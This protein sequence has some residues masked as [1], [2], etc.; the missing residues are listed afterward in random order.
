MCEKEKPTMKIDRLI[1]RIRETGSPIALGLDTRFE[2][3]PNEF[4]KGDKRREEIHT[5]ITEFNE[6]LMEG[7]KDIVPCVKIQTACYERYGEPGIEAMSKTISAARDM[8]YIVI[9]DGKRGDIG[10]TVAEYSKAYLAKKASFPADF[11]TVSPYMGSDSIE[12]FFEDCKETGSGLFVLVKTSNPSSGEFQDLT[13]SD[14][15][16]LYEHVADKVSEWGKG[17][18][19]EQ[20]YSS[21]GAVVGATYPGQG[22]ALRK[23]MPGTFFLVPGYGAQGASAA[24]VA[25]CFDDEGS[26]AIVAASRSLLC[27]YKKEG[28]NDFTGAAIRE[29]LRM[30]GEIKSALQRRKR[31]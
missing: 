10:A 22:I 26:G 9:V 12:P 17:L 27:A 2:Y 4:I 21:V 19:G 14:G 6:K 15:R 11:L 31:D 13:V 18:M 8:G 3:I 30:K 1:E 28:N 5:A 20:G 24:D 25:G 7:L 29:A 16:P 23:Q